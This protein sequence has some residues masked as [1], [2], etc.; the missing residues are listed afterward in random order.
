MIFGRGMLPSHHGID[1]SGVDT[2][3]CI[4]AGEAGFGL[5]LEVANE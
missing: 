3:I 5:G 1:G 2:D 4:G